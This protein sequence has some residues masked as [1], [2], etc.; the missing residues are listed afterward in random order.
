MPSA[1]YRSGAAI[2]IWLA[3]WLTSGSLNASESFAPEKMKIDRLKFL[4]IAVNNP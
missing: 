4:T 3:T 2:D 1:A